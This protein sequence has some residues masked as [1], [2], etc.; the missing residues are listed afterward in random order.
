MPLIDMKHML[1]HAYQ[2]GY[3]VGAFEVMSLDFLNGIITAAEQ[4]RAPVILNLAES[5]FEQIN[6]E[7]MMPAVE[8]AAIRAQVPV[9][10]HFDHGTCLESA[11]NGIRLG[12]NSVQLD[13]SHL[14]F[15]ENTKLTKQI[16]E[17]AHA[18][19]IPVE[20][21]VEVSSD[22]LDISLTEAKDYV[23]QTG[24]DFLSISSDA[25]HGRMKDKL[26]LDDARLKQINAAL[27]IPLVMHGGSGLA[28]DQYGQWI[29]NGISKINYG[30]ALS[31]MA[32]KQ[33]RENT[34]TNA[35]SD[36]TG[37]VKGINCAVA[38]EVERCVRLWGAADRAAEVLLQCQPWNPVEHLIVYNTEGLDDRGAETMMAEGRRVLS[39]IPGVRE[40]YSGEA[41]QAD[42][43]YRY[44][45]LIRFCHPAVID[46]YREHPAHVAFADN[47]FRPVAGKRI[48]IDFQPVN[49]P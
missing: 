21:G 14:S 45:W 33:I 20:G 25:V 43:P 44:T 39:A 4:A 28:D 36:Y 1:Q 2:H 34:R 8:A 12:C 48:S 30:T 37:L 26:R 6:F 19:G 3:A 49:T 31:D 42:A 41:V 47:L 40:V 38:I 18:C 17:M 5:C 23:E 24:V 10:I 32:A 16:V 29:A 9:A 13:R 35:S 27:Q 15:A 11:V 46:S 22:E 7:L